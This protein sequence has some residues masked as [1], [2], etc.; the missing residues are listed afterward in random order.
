[1]PYKEIDKETGAI[2]FKRTPEEKELILLKSKYRKLENNYESLQE[3]F[4]ELANK[5]DLVL[6]LSSKEE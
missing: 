6:N 2:I 4:D 5:L 1:M 3:K